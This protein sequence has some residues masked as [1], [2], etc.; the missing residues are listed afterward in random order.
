MI[1]VVSASDKIIVPPRTVMELSRD[2]INT[3]ETVSCR[4]VVLNSEMNDN[5]SYRVTIL[6]PANMSVNGIYDDQYTST[7]FD[8]DTNIYTTNFSLKPGAQSYTSLHMY[9]NKSG[10][11][12]IGY[13]VDLLDEN[14]TVHSSV[15]EAR[16]VE[17]IDSPVYTTN[18]STD[19]STNNVKSPE[20]SSFCVGILIICAALCLKHRS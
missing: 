6:I 16:Y 10:I 8:S 11:Y 2:I 13:E 12:K 7:V 18:N 19:N 4:V 17:V 20:L 15:F 14:N 9:T 1:T 5:L 3:N